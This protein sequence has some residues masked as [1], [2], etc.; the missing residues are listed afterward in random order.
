MWSSFLYDAEKIFVNV[1]T[2][3]VS[4]ICVPVMRLVQDMPDVGMLFKSIMFSAQFDAAENTD[5]VG[6]IINRLNNPAGF[7]LEDF[8]T[9]LE[10]LEAGAE[11]PGQK[12]EETANVTVIFGS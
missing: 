3:E 12:P 10:G 8:Q 5:Y 7:L 6:K 9:L 2:L 4:M 1:S 11:N